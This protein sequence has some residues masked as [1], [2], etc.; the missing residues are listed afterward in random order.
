[1]NGARFEASKV[2]FPPKYLWARVSDGPESNAS[3]KEVTK[4]RGVTAQEC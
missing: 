4:L 2:K 1:M 3:R